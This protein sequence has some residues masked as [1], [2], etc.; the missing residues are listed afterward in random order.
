MLEQHKPLPGAA[1]SSDMQDFVNT[2]QKDLDSPSRHVALQLAHSNPLFR[3][4]AV[5]LFFVQCEQSGC[6][7]IVNVLCKILGKN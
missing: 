3:S 6:S 2:C 4:V 1:V 5:Q 7:N